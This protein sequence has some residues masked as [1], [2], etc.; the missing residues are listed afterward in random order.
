MSRRIGQ[1][2]GL[3]RQTLSDLLASQM[4]DPR[5]KAMTTIIQVDTSL[6]LKNAKVFISTLGDSS[7][8]NAALEALNSASGFLQRELK[9]RLS[10]KNT[11][12]LRFLAD[13]SIERGSYL[14]QRIREVRSQDAPEDQI[15]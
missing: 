12:R 2:N 11:P 5:L 14:L 15:P 4:N 1:V 8:R 10:L 3:L 9:V 7:E 13:N 6:D